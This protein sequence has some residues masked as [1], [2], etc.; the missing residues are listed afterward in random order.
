MVMRLF[1]IAG[2]V[3]VG[4]SLSSVVLQSDSAANPTWL[5]RR[6]SIDGFATDME[7]FGAARRLYG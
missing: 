3:K 7:P 1:R 2:N 6:E 5:L 4:E